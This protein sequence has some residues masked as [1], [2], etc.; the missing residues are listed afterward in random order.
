MDQANK[1]I[2]VTPAEMRK[3]V[4]AWVGNGQTDQSIMRTLQLYTAIHNLEYLGA[5]ADDNAYY[6]KPTEM[7]LTD[8]ADYTLRPIAGLLV[9]VA[10]VKNAPVKPVAALPSACGSG[11]KC[12]KD[13]PEAELTAGLMPAGWVRVTEG[14]I[15]EGDKCWDE[16]L[17]VWTNVPKHGLGYE[18]HQSFA[19]IR[20]VD[21]EAPSKP[22]RIKVLKKVIK[23]LARR[24][25]KP[26]P[27]KHPLILSEPRAEL[28]VY[29][30][31]DKTYI[32]VLTSNPPKSVVGVEAKT[33]RELQGALEE[34]LGS[35]EQGQQ[36]P[37]ESAVHLTM[38]DFRKALGL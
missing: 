38:D 7:E 17:G 8:G 11:C 24:H 19:V 37:E 12:K 29:R 26:G 5:T 31:A 23:Q 35:V 15:I 25:L 20:K 21:E 32:A 1:V 3:A 9:S 6:L 16:T 30:G 22:D 36:A 18:P 27:A 10:S 33:L 34:C 2:T 4:F 14:A 28:K 13:K